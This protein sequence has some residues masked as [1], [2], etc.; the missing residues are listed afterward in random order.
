MSLLAALSDTVKAVVGEVFEAVGSALDE[1]HFAMEALCDA[2]VFRERHTAARG[3]RQEDNV[4]A[5]HAPLSLCLGEQP[6]R[7]VDRSDGAWQNR[8]Q[9]KETKTD[10]KHKT[11]DTSDMGGKPGSLRI[12]ICSIG[13]ID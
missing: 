12:P 6:E 5:N 11:S 13:S 10:P 7:S 4:S 8:S 9:P 1:F 3:S 2:I